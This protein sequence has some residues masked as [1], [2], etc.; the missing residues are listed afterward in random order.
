MDLLWLHNGEL[1]AAEEQDQ[2]DLVPAAA[3][4]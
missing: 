3:T 2:Q 1:V 4:A